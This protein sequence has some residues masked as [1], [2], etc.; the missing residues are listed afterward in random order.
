MRSQATLL[1]LLLLALPGLLLPA[2]TL[3]HRCGC[4]ELAPQRP[5]C[6]SH[7]APRPKATQPT[8]RACCRKAHDAERAPT[9]VLTGECCGCD[10]LPLADDQPA[11]RPPEPLTPPTTEALALASPFEL[12]PLRTTPASGLPGRG[13]VTTRPPPPDRHRTLPLR[14]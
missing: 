9:P 1:L 6:C 3:W 7:D 4:G 14:L 8:V 12:P 13:G 2:G 11:P 10:W 5:S